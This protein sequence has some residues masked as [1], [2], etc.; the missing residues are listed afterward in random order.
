VEAAEETALDGGCAIMRLEVRR[1][2]TASLALF[3]GGGYRDLGVYPEY[4]EDAMDAIRLERRVSPEL[5][6]QLARVPFYPQTLEFT[7]GPAALMMA[8][9]ALRPSLALSRRDE[10]R[11]WR[12]STTLFMT[13]GHSGCGRPSRRHR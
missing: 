7:C 13:S 12:E 10:L 8:M 3:R 9:K 6:Q 11:L 5:R 1:D 4:Y 2:N